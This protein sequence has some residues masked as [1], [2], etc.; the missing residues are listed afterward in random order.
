[1][2]FSIKKTVAAACMAAF[3]A[4]SF[5][6]GII[7]A[8]NGRMSLA[9]AQ[10]RIELQQ[11]YPHYKLKQS[12][13]QS[14]GHG[15]KYA[16]KQSPDRRS[17]YAQKQAGKHRP[18]MHTRGPVSRTWEPVRN[19]PPHTLKTWRSAPSHAVKSKKPAAGNIKPGLKW[20]APARP[21]PTAPYRPQPGNG[22]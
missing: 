8:A 11:K 12:Q 9:Q 2:N 14:P 10:Q 20:K 3:L 22:R 1:M 17:K 15:Y 5:M 16:Q 4:T 19:A 21:A 13:K 6:P 7:E 18:A